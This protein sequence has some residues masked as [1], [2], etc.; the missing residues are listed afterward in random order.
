MHNLQIVL[1]IIIPLNTV[2]LLL[3][4]FMANFARILGVC[5]NFAGNCVD[6]PFPKTYI[7]ILY[8]SET[9]QNRI[10]LTRA[11]RRGRHIFDLARSILPLLLPP[12]ERIILESVFEDR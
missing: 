4:S 7:N 1:T 2:T 12:G 3:R 8:K 11:L 6:V 10:I 5:K 9:L